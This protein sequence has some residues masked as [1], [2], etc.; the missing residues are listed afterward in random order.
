M[1]RATNKTHNEVLITQQLSKLASF[2]KEKALNELALGN[3]Q[4]QMK[5]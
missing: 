3:K 2:Q 4:P 5:L 1:R